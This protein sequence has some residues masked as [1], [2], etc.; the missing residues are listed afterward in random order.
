MFKIKIIA[1]GKIKEDYFI[2]AIEE[3]LKRLGRYAEIKVTEV[4]KESLCAEPNDKEKQIILERE[5]EAI[6][7]EIKGKAYALAI[8]GKKISSNGFID[9]IKASK[10]AGE[11]ITFIIGGSYG[12]SDKVKR[13]TTLVSFS[14]MTF[15]HTL[16]RVMLIEQIYRAFNVMEGGKYHK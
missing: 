7:K 3:Y 2:K 16:F 12:L 1:V 4:K 10:N 6:I 9:L 11:E 8:E 15:P 13:L 5:G 14:D